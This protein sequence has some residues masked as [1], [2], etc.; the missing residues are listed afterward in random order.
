MEG[1]GHYRSVAAGAW[2]C[3]R[4]VGLGC[5]VLSLQVFPP[6]LS[7]HPM[8]SFTAQAELPT[9]YPYLKCKTRLTT[10]LQHLSDRGCTAPHSIFHTLN[11]LE[12][13][14]SWVAPCTEASVSDITTVHPEEVDVIAQYHQIAAL[15]TPALML[16]SLSPKWLSCLVGFCSKVLASWP[17]F[18]K[19]LIPPAFP[20]LRVAR[21]LR[22]VS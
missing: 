16:D 8:P 15:P 1:S 18:R 14:P 17:L 11:R 2:E 22:L 12:P 7:P 19:S 13:N 6:L 10:Q 5:A 3:R 20:L 21:E 4:T 9:Q